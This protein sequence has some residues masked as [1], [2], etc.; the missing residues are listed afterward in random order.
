MGHSL[1]QYQRTHDEPS[2]QAPKVLL[3]LPAIRV[4]IRDCNETTTRKEVM[5][6]IAVI[7]G[8][9][10]IWAHDLLIAAQYVS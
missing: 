8:N 3:F 1:G 10:A 4:K 9:L 6:N 5:F 7:A 2:I